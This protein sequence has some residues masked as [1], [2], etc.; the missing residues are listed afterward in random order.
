MLSV[1]CSVT[2]CSA[3]PQHVEIPESTQDVAFPTVAVVRER[4]RGL[5]CWDAEENVMLSAAVWETIAV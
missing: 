2:G 5:L 3:H 4:T 1:V